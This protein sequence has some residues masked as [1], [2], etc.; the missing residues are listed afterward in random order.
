MN[1]VCVGS[2]HEMALLC[3][4]DDETVVGVDAALLA[5]PRLVA[6][7][8]SSGVKHRKL[9]QPMIVD[10]AVVTDSSSC[11]STMDDEEVVLDR[12]YRASVADD[13]DVEPRRR[14]AEVALE[15]EF[16]VCAVL[17]FLNMH[18]M[19][20]ASGT[21]RSLVGALGLVAEV[22]IT[23]RCLCMPSLVSR[24]SGARHLSVEG[25]I[26]LFHAMRLLAWPLQTSLI[27]VKQLNF[28]ISGDEIGDDTRGFQAWE[29]G[30]TT[31][32]RSGCLRNIEC[33]TFTFHGRLKGVAHY[34]THTAFEA[35]FLNER[36]RL[37]SLD[38]AL[39]VAAS[40]PE[41][42]S[43]LA[44]ELLDR[45]AN[46][47][48]ATPRGTPALLL[49]AQSNSRD[50]VAALIAHGADVNARSHV[51][52]NKTALHCAVANNYYD[53]FGPFDDEEVSSTRIVAYSS[54]MLEKRKRPAAVRF[55]RAAVVQLL[56]DA[57]VDVNARDAKGNTPLITALASAASDLDWDTQS[58]S[59][60]IAVLLTASANASLRNSAGDTALTAA[61][62]LDKPIELLSTLAEAEVAPRTG[63]TPRARPD[64]KKQRLRW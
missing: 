18:D 44:V 32:A 58:V 25:G 46:P 62:D 7:L 41:V 13:D 26:E 43:W 37:V 22:K 36:P 42:D 12:L 45:G 38:C 53:S 16:L 15:N 55:E 52:G 11:A 29:A 64:I 27:G 49:A 6:A 31:L 5:E 40:H 54:P 33:L 35:V 21:R 57:K 59:K 47:N 61:V 39:L 10:T 51:L 24:F 8:A 20:R 1:A 17:T 3:D 2:G 50:V 9:C 56:V 14:S 23:P 28:E 34:L 60:T 30:L 4:G 48:A 19:V 63:S